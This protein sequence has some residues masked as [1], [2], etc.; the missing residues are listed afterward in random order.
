MNVLTFISL[1]FVASISIDIKNNQFECSLEKGEIIDTLLHSSNFYNYYVN[2]DHRIYFVKEGNN[3]IE[4]NKELIK[5]DSFKLPIRTE[6]S[7]IYL[8]ENYIVI[9]SFDLGSSENVVVI[10]K[11]NSLEEI[12]YLEKMSVAYFDESEQL[13]VP[14]MVDDWENDPEM[15]LQKIQNLDTIYSLGFNSSTR[16]IKNKIYYAYDR[17]FKRKISKDILKVQK[18]NI[19]EDIVDEI[20][21]QHIGYKDIVFI[22]E[23]QYVAIDNDK[24]YLIDFNGN[25]QKEWNF[26]NLIGCQFL[27]S[28]K[29]CWIY[30][31]RSG[32]NSEDEFYFMRYRIEI[33]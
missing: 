21:I 17:Y 9:C 32:D 10:Y 23:T 19:Q 8:S 18:V 14:Y 7:S 11:K 24:I 16:I 15:Y 1:F 12:N 31:W 30:G 22:F 2:N 29:Y 6:V 20:N 28:D 25:V 3:I 4:F 26:P 5:I 27:F 33:Y 13:F